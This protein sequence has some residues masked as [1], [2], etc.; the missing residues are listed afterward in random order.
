[1]LSSITP[2]GERSRKQRW[3]VTVAAH[4][5][6]GLVGGAAAG[7]A[8]GA[9]GTALPLSAGQ[10]LGLLAL[11]LLAGAALD[12][13]VAGIPLPSLERQVDERWLRRYRGWVYGG[14]FGLQLGS[15]LVTI[16]SSSAVYATF[17]G[18]LLSASLAGGLLIGAAFG[19]TRGLAPLATWRLG[20]PS[21]LAGFHRQLARH[22]PAAAAAAIA[23][24]LGLGAL[25]GVLVLR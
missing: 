12:T 5:L 3:G 6:G 21:R 13:G 10:R 18:A 24:Q 16:V 4:A 9:L 7:A 20:S 11:V 14:G 1:M 15:G 25:S 17:A 19:L 2:L 22:A 8:L 23:V